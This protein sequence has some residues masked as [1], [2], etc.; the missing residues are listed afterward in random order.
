[1]CK[2]EAWTVTRTEGGLLE[3]S[4]VR[5]LQWILDATLKDKKKEMKCLTSNAIA[6]F[7]Q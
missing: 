7:K 1:M 5:M 2:T 4:E 6:A 3:R